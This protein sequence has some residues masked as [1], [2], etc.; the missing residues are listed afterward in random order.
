MRIWTHSLPVGNCSHFDQDLSRS[1]G[2]LYRFHVLYCAGIV[3]AFG[4]IWT[5]PTYNSSRTVVADQILEI[6]VDAR[7]LKAIDFGCSQHSNCTQTR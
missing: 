7:Q 1:C 3:L 6:H 4:D 2:W 5:C